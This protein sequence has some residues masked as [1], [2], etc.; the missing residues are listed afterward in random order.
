MGCI[1]SKPNDDNI[2]STQGEIDSSNEVE[3]ILIQSRLKEL[4]KFKILILGAGE[5]GKSTI[6]KALR[7][8]HKGKLDMSDD[9]KDRI[10][11]TLHENVITTMRALLEGGDKLGIYL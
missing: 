6:V 4:F 3:Q 5:S 10:I 9:E 11:S 2:L 1:E 8:I 7:L